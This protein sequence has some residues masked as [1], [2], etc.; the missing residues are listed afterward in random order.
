MDTEKWINSEEGRRKIKQ[1]ISEYEQEKR[2]A[3]RIEESSK[4]KYPNGK[5]VKRGDLFEDLDRKENYK[6]NPKQEPYGYQMYVYRINEDDTVDLC[7]NRNFALK[8]NDVPFD[9]NVL[10][11]EAPTSS[12][13]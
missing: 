11:K 7:L 8:L 4:L 2:E 13:S 12:V 9:F 1:L 3:K 5:K 10:P 6:N